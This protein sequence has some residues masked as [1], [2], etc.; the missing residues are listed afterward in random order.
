MVTGG[1]QPRGWGGGADGPIPPPGPVM[2]GSSASASPCPPSF[3][4]VEG[5]DRQPT[6][7]HSRLQGIPGDPPW[8][9]QK[10]GIKKT[11]SDTQH[12]LSHLAPSP[13]PDEEFIICTHRP[14]QVP[15]PH[16][17]L[18]FL[19][20][21]GVTNNNKISPKYYRKALGRGQNCW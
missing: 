5:P 10:H 11:S 19:W 17:Q 3:P 20:G 6:H 13:T 4:Q 9:S 12:H 7:A 18:H 16:Q 15:N 2:R 1:P 14:N 8:N 21:R